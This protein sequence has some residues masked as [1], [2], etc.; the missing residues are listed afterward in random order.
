[1][2]SW[3]SSIAKK[4]QVLSDGAWSEPLSLGN[5]INTEYDELTGMVTPDGQYFFFSRFNNGTS[6]IYWVKAS[7]IEQLRP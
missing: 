1:M 3:Q 6:D 7:F 4:E 2:Y 5:E